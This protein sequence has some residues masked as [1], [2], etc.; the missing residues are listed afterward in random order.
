VLLDGLPVARGGRID[1]D[2]LEDGGGDTV[3]EGFVDDVGVACDP[4]DVS[5]AGKAVV[6]VDIED[7]FDGEGAA[8]E[9]PGCGVHDAFGFAGGA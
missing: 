7:V 1:G 9:V 4:A 3:E 5:H 6:G 8:E 2:A